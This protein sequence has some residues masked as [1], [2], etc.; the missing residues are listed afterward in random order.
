MLVQFDPAL[1]DDTASAVAETHLRDIVGAKDKLA[2]RA[3]QVSAARNSLGIRVLSWR[4]ASLMKSERR[5]P[6]SRP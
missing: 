4:P 2:G 6:Y 3:Q 5:L 1:A